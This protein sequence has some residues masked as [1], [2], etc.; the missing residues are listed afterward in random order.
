M[1][2]HKDKL[3]ELRICIKR[4]LTTTRV[5]GGPIILLV[6]PT[7]SGKTTAVEVLS[8]SVF[9]TVN[10]VQFLDEGIGHDE[11]TEIEKFVLSSGVYGGQSVMS[12]ESGKSLE[13]TSPITVMILEVSNFNF[14]IV[15]W[16]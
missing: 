16:F 6:G 8:R 13:C 3:K 7:G 12:S 11:Y 9:G 2:V 10:V 5:V 15:V 1:A 14:N 4:A